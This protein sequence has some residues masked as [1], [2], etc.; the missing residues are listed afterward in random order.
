MKYLLTVLLLFLL[1]ISCFYQADLLGQETVADAANLLNSKKYEEAIALLEKLHIE[2]PESTDISL[3][4]GIAYLQIEQ[5]DSAE[6]YFIEVTMKKT[7]S[8]PARYSLAMLYEKKGSYGEAIGEWLKV[9]SL[10]DREDLKN[11]AEKHIKQL[12]TKK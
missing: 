1:N 12:E 11:L 10:T 6:R 3:T 2:N 9:I 5:Y 7:D 4:L 8:L